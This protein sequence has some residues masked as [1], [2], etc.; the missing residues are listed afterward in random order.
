MSQYR[1]MVSR[2]EMIVKRLLMVLTSALAAASLPAAGSPGRPARSMAGQ[3]PQ[4]AATSTATPVPAP[5][6]LADG[7]GGLEL[8]SAPADL[9]LGVGCVAYVPVEV[10]S[11]HRPI[12]VDARTLIHTFVNDI[13]APE[14][15]ES[16]MLPVGTL[17]RPQ[18]ELKLQTLRMRSHTLTLRFSAGSDAVRVVCTI[19]PVVEPHTPLFG[20]HS[21]PFYDGPPAP[22]IQ[23]WGPDCGACVTSDGDPPGS[24]RDI[25]CA[26]LQD[27]CRCHPFQE[28]F[29]PQAD[30]HTR[31]AAP[32]MQRYA[33]QFLR[34]VGGW[35]Q[36][37]IEPGRYLWDRL[38]WTFDSLSPQERDY[39]PLFT[40]II[41]GNFGWM[42]C[43]AYTNPDRSVGFYDPDNTYLLEQYGTYVRELTAR[44]APEL[45]F[46]ETGNE[47]CYGFYLCPCID[48]GGPPCDATSG[49]N[50]P[51]C[52]LGPESE[53]FAQAYGPFLSTSANVAAEAM[54]E[55]NPD[56]LLIAGAL[57]KTG[58]ELTATTRYMIEQGLLDQGNVAIMIHQFPLPQPNWL[59]HSVDCAYYQDPN[60]PYWLPAGCQT[61]P[62]FDDYISPAGRP[63]H[64]QDVWRGIDERIDA[65]L[66]LHDAEDLGV[67]D[68]FYLF[69]TELHGGWHDTL[70][71]KPD[72]TTTPA[73]ETMAGLRIGAINAHQHFLGM[74][75]VSAPSDPAAFNLM[76]KYLAGATPVYAWDAP[77][78]DADYSGL[79][80]KLFTRGAEDI[81][82]FWSNAGGPLQLAL[83]PSADP[84]HFRQVTLT[85]LDDV[86]GAVAITTT[87]SST[88]PPSLSI[89]PL[90]EFCFLSVISDRPGFG[91]L[92][93]IAITSLRTPRRVRGR[94]S[95]GTGR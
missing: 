83:T 7:P 77:L 76:V 37:Q 27:S 30:E 35:G 91:W 80:Y 52:E 64:A 67:L 73:R 39:S 62:P 65:S 50:R 22:F 31:H 20:L 90:R 36:V 41:Y 40:G 56:A 59:S 44:Y 47:P 84:T 66:L 10:E 4:P 6:V 17:S 46:I 82:A 16:A 63:V 95:A 60:D 89:Q 71:G 61:A 81:I 93:D 21:P 18:S 15:G 45:R 72:D 43:P 26:R 48:P 19:E 38:D 14:P 74:E 23:V 58:E 70:G 34:S 85:R 12:A 51:A 69:D 75:F 28:F 57:E 5:I 79:V 25:R 94:V 88:P 68:R 13:T 55:A 1:R 87:D 32:Q 92:A 78:T 29:D 2:G 49:P 11:F 53:E 9:P 33:N 86:D 24:T 3:A 8:V 54:A 42:T